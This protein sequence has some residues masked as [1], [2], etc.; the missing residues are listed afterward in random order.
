MVSKTSTLL[1]LALAV[2]AS[3]SVVS[4]R[5]EPGRALLTADEYNSGQCWAYSK[6]P[7][8]GGPTGCTVPPTPS[9]SPDFVRGIVDVIIK[10]GVDAH[11]I[12][13]ACIQANLNLA[14]L[15]LIGLKVNIAVFV[16][17]LLKLCAVDVVALCTVLK[18]NLDLVAFLLLHV[19]VNA[20][21]AIL[22]KLFLQLL[23]V[24]DLT[25]LAK[26][27]VSI[28]VYIIGP[29]L[30]GCGSAAANLKIL[31]KVCAQINLGWYQALKPFCPT[32]IDIYVS[33]LN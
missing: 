33:V 10:I 2:F 3:A 14:L 18:L 16:T 29:V 27:C 17:I 7:G 25:V 20:N 9:T 24:V 12:V 31:L 5:T 8:H 26:V 15:V 30:D 13:L 19:D 22:V 6:C 11:V 32:I 1:L 4:A 21:L 28:P 23:A